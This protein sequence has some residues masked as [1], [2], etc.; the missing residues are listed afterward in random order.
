MLSGLVASN[1]AGY[2]AIAWTSGRIPTMFMTRLRLQAS[3][4]SAISVRTFL[5]LF[6]RKWGAPILALI[7]PKEGAAPLTLRA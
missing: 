4:L 2:A 5:S 3:T 6:M 7:V 1:E